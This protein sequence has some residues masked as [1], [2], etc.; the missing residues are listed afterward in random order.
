M[1]IFGLFEYARKTSSDTNPAELWSAARAGVVR[2]YV[3]IA[4][5]R[6]PEFLRFPI[7]SPAITLSLPIFQN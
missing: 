1:L 5:A 6:T 3:E 2:A 4:R 7:R